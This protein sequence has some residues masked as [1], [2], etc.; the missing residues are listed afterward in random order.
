MSAFIILIILIVL[1]GGGMFYLVWGR[2][3]TAGAMSE[4]ELTEKIL[5]SRSLFAD[6]HDY[7]VIP[8]VNYWK[9]SILPNIYKEFEKTVSRFRINVLKIE[10]WLLKL[11]NYIRGKRNA[12]CNGN[13]GQSPYWKD[14]NDFKNELNGNGEKKE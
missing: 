5:A 1:S 14:V 13:G 3:R 10:H 2:F 9:N 8:S 6:F 11:T 12:Q 7:I 4:S